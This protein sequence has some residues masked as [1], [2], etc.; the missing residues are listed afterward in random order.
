MTPKVTQL[1]S[2]IQILVSDT[3]EVLKKVLLKSNPHTPGRGTTCRE[4]ALG[5]ISGKSCFFPSPDFTLRWTLFILGYPKPSP[6][7]SHVT[8][9]D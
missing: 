8:Q 9:G 3:Q 5:T 6:P 7:L 2:G 4:W 1:I